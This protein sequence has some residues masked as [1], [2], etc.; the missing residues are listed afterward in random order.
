MR[1]AKRSDRGGSGSGWPCP[2][3]HIFCGEWTTEERTRT[4]EGLAREL[5]KQALSGGCVP[6]IIV[7]LPDG[8]I[9]ACLATRLGEKMRADSIGEI[10]HKIAG[11]SKRHR[12]ATP[13]DIASLLA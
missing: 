4:D 10:C 11:W 1:T 12:A 6:W 7:K 5:A 9:T 2:P 3:A 13:A 8:K